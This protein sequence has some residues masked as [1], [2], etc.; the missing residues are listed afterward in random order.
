MSSPE[1][2]Q[3]IKKTA[4][5]EHLEDV[6]HDINPEAAVPKSRGANTQLDD[7][8]R[9]LAQVGGSI[10]VSAADRKR[11]LRSVDLWVCVP[12]CIVYCIQSLDKSSLTYAAVFSLQAD[13]KLH[14]I[15]YSWLSR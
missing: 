14:G 12:M 11:V 6:A 15:E 9:I 4:L 13:A 5:V 3:D 10:E 8:A 1:T 7:A 2:E